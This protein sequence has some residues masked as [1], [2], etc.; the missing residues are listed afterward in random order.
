[1]PETVIVFNYDIIQF[2][3]HEEIG[4]LLHKSFTRTLFNYTISF[5]SAQL[6]V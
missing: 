5:K 1:M 3:Y 4:L 6:H 2:A